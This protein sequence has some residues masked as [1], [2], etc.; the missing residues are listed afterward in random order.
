VPN[1]VIFSNLTRTNLNQEKPDLLDQS[2]DQLST[3][4]HEKSIIL[5]NNF[6]VEPELAD[7]SPDWET[8]KF[9]FIGSDNG[10]VKRILLKNSPGFSLGHIGFPTQESNVKN[11]PYA[12]PGEIEAICLTPDGKT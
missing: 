4:N 10:E 6:P 9:M 2:K 11:Y 7:A 1:K 5:Q 12:F 3:K 8:G